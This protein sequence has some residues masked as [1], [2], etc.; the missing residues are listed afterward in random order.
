MGYGTVS[1]FAGKGKAL[2]LLMKSRT[3]VHAF[4]D[5]GLSCNV[6]DEMGNGIKRFVCE[7]YGQKCKKL[8]Y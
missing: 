6:S 3:Y 8:I 4:M 7:L 1:A 2:K 5:L